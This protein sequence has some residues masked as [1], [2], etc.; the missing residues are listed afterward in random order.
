MS[1]ESIHA[2]HRERL[3]TKYREYGL[4][5]FT[6]IEAI[7]LLL[8]YA[9]PRRSTN[10]LAHALL[11]RFHSFRGVLEAD[12][13]ELESVPG[14]GENA[15]LLLKLVT[16]LNERYGISGNQKNI[17]IS[18]SAEAGAYLMPYFTYRREEC[19][20]L[21]CLDMAGCVIDCH[22]LAK[23]S[24][25]MVGLVARD[26]VDLALRDKA[27]RVILAHNHPSGVALP[28]R[29]DVDATKQ[30]YDVLKL[31]EVE[32]MDHII[33]SEGDFV[34]MRDSGYFRQF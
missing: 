22:P 21:L 12:L 23:G 4:T 30:I 10:E 31:I 14:I 32:L 9:I 25:G 29:A 16:G 33:V 24:P 2:G 17:R 3:K 6:D 5:C 13:S 27:A 26:L 20:V 8:F 18:G 19:S 34:S 15:A 11:N 1:D 7:E 28:S